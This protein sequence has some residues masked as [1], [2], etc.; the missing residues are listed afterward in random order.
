M[1]A[2]LLERTIAPPLTDNDT[3][4][5]YTEQMYSLYISMF[6]EKITMLAE[7]PTHA[8]ACEL[9]EY[10]LS[11]YRPLRAT[12]WT[13]KLSDLYGRLEGK[14]EKVDWIRADIIDTG[15]EV[16]LLTI[17]DIVKVI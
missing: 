1:V 10:Y 12:R 2:E 11:N 4:V 13:A 7:R 9:L 5:Q 16:Q 6:K 15:V 17:D 3:F 8:K 14:L